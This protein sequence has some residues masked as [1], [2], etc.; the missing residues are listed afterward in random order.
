MTSDFKRTL[1]TAVIVGRLDSP[2]IDS[3]LR[4]NHISTSE[5]AG[6]WETYGRAVVPLPW[7]PAEKAL[8]IFGSDTRGTIWGVIDLTRE[9]GVSAWEWWADATIR[10]VD[11]IAVDAGL[12]YS[13]EPSVKYRGIFL[14]AGI[15]GMNPWVSKT[16]DPTQGNMGPRSYAKI[17]EL[18]WRLKANTIWPAMT[19]ADTPFNAIPENARVAADYA[20]VRGSSHVEMLL[21]T[22]STEWDAKKRG[23]YNW[24]VSR[25]QMIDYWTGAVREFGSYENL[26]TVGL[27]NA[28]DFPMQGANTP[29]E[30]GDVLHDAITEQ[31]KI[32]SSVLKKP[33][34]EAPQ[35]FTAYKEVLPAYDT[36]RIHLPD[37]VTINWPDDD[38]G[39]IR[40]LS[41]AAER[42]RSGGSGVYY[43]DTFWGPPMFYVWLQ[44]T[45]PA[46]MWEEMTKA[47]HF[48]ARRLWVLNVGS[49][50]P[51]EFLTQLFLELAF[52]QRAFAKSSDVRAYLR[53]WSAVNF[54]DEHADK[55]TD[56]LWN[57]YRLAFE[58]YP[59]YMGW[60]EVFPETAVRETGYNMLDFG[61]ENA[62]RVVAYRTIVKEA[63]EVA[64]A[65]PKD[66][67]AT[68]YQLVQYQVDSAANINFRQLYLDKAITYGLQH[69]ASANIY[70]AKAQTA[71]DRIVADAHYYNDVMLGGKWRHMVSIA[72]NTLPIFEKPHLPTWSDNGD[73][74]CGVQVEGGGYFD[75]VG[76]FTP[77]LPAFH[78]E[79]KETYYIDVFAQGDFDADWTA[80][81][82]APV[83]A[84]RQAKLDLAQTKPAPWI[85]LS[86]TSGR[87]SVA[88]KHLEDRI[89]VSIDWSQAPA[90]GGG[91]VI[92]SGPAFAQLIAV[93]VRLARPNPAKN[94]SFI[95]AS[96]IVSMYATHADSLSD[97]WEVLAD[98]GHTGADLRTPLDMQGVNPADEAAV[99]KAPSAVYRFATTTADDRATLRA[100]ALPTFPITSKD[101][102]R[103]AVSIDGGPMHVLDF[104]APEFSEA[105]RQHALTNKAIEQLPEL[106]LAPGAHSLTVYGLDPGV[107]LDRF[108]IAFTGA[109]SAYG[110][111]PETKIR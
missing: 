11:R 91:E 62:R 25:D 40:R 14:N 34:S 84:F 95:E 111:V 4:A 109:P 94:V 81:A 59:E 18:M 101:G 32:L 93:H 88:D 8:V 20:I 107:T 17:F 67:K 19:N 98:L 77:S 99:R 87:F 66:R 50:K 75:S 22:N 44:T 58:R 49:I 80:T 73:K 16:F 1:G 102:V 74:K 55:V 71:E 106:R 60:T 72:P 9:M 2:A 79:L 28:D 15:H 86:K 47:W 23:P 33:A 39:Y 76:W 24:F 69:R 56:I 38:F 68:F 53:H 27:R 21:R 108:E 48:G 3:I 61:D 103:I 51:G 92:L 70:S 12:R 110:P 7:N 96:R 37:D 35:V 63:A 100:I 78:P 46:L 104:F 90:K 26:Y 65:L 45:N 6:K 82:T 5:I 89:L 52:D 31:R 105:W 97:G 64:A 57:Y 43:H 30:M 54:G 83:N 41:D 85:K 13:R 42:K 29:E 36:G 10:K